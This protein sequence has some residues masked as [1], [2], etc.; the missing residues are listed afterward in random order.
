MQAASAFILPKFYHRAATSANRIQRKLMLTSKDWISDFR[1]L[2]HFIH[3]WHG[4]CAPTASSSG[5]LH[6]SGRIPLVLAMSYDLCGTSL[7]KVVGF[8]RCESANDLDLSQTPIVFCT[9]NQGVYLFA[10]EDAS[11]NPRVL[12]RVN[13]PG[14]PWQLED[15]R[16]CRFLLQLCILEAV[17][18]PPYGAYACW[19]SEDLIK[20]MLERWTE[21]DLAPWHMPD[22]PT[23]FYQNGDAFAV[24][25]PNDDGYTFQCGA[26]QSTALQCVAP[27]VDDGWNVHLR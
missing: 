9:E 5:T 10:L 14:A 2:E 3:D 1:R 19:C 21:L 16:L 26:V 6:D 12:A 25:I 18:C 24:V 15:E 7:H 23:R 13:E 8:H 4:I 11:E 22:Y 27:F 17:I 20:Q